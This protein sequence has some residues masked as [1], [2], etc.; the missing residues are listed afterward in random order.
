MPW[1]DVGAGDWGGGGACICCGVCVGGASAGGTS[2]GGA[3]AGGA[4]GKSRIL[5][6]NAE[7]KSG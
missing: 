4:V 1:T 5:V 2:A 7:E 3:C 6:G